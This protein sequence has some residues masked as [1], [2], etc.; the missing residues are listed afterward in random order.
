MS[1]RSDI[2]TALASRLASITS[3]NGYSTNVKN[4][5]YDKIPMGLI[6]NSYQLP[7]IFVLDAL[8]SLSLAHKVMSGIWNIKLQLWHEQISDSIMQTFVRDVFKAIYANN[9]TAQIED[10]FR[11]H[12]SVYEILPLNIRGDLNMIEGNRI[13][14]LNFEIHYRTKL[15]DL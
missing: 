2:L 15:Y 10:A 13:Y 6:L 12:S 9:S 4:V 8:D 14:E 11:I 5:Y 1:I 3:V 7:V